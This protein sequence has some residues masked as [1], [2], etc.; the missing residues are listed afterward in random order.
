MHLSSA[1]LALRLLSVTVLAGASVVLGHAAARPAE[2]TPVGPW[3]W[4]LEPAPPPVVHGFVRP[5][6]PYAAGHRGVDLAARVGQPVL[7]AASGVVAFAGT[8]AGRP[9]VAVE[10]PGGLRT[11]YEP[12]EPALPVG[13]TVR[14]GDRIGV[15]GAAAGHCLPGSCLHWGLRRG[16][17]YLDPL[18]R[19]DADE[20]RLLPF[21]TAVRAPSSPYVA[22]DV[23]PPAEVPDRGP[24]LARG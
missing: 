8:V 20:V 4:P 10:H 14:H 16:S 3:A 17:N 22:R 6:G 21:W 19:V 2:P 7:A 11:T 13:A 9:V 1:R 12:V 5:P 23:L 24:L 15:L 18:A